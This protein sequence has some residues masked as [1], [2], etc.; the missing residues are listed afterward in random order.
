MSCFLV[1]AG[2]GHFAVGTG[3]I[4]GGGFQF[5]EIFVDEIGIGRGDLFEHR[6]SAFEFGRDGGDGLVGGQRVPYIGGQ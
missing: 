3:E 1:A 5:T 2:L 4:E 6:R